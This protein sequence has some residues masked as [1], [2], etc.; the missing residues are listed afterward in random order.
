[1]PPGLERC[2][3]RCPPH[4]ARS[5]LGQLA[6]S[7]PAV[8]SCYICD[9]PGWRQ[10]SLASRRRPAPSVSGQRVSSQ[11]SPGPTAVCRAGQSRG[12]AGPSVRAVLSVDGPGWAGVEPM[13]DAVLRSRRRKIHERMVVA[14][15]QYAARGWPVCAGAYPADRAGQPGRACS[16]DRI[17]CPAPGAHPLSPAWQRQATAD[18]AVIGQWWA[19]RPKASI[20]LVTGRTCDVLDVPVPAGAAALTR[21]ERSGIKPGPVAI[22]AQ[23]RALFLVATR[24]PLA[25]EHEWWSCGLDC[26][27][28]TVPE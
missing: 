27:P 18:K 15:T 11:E 16:C 26:E 24:A 22:S 17:G 14:A 8:C 5:R 6:L 23:D 7:A 4:G 3:S 21:M 10:S 1:M 19:A 20:I 28:E 25:D 9:D 2:R 13:V 12:G